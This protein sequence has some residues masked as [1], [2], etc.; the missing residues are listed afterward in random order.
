MAWRC[1]SAGIYVNVAH[2]FRTHR[3]LCGCSFACIG[4]ARDLRHP[5]RLP[6][7]SSRLKSI[8]QRNATA[9]PLHSG[10]ADF[11]PSHAIATAPTP[12]PTKKRCN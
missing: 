7:I 3:T 5:Y 11:V 8:S 10:E 4:V 2:P 6:L 9:V 1:D 12:P